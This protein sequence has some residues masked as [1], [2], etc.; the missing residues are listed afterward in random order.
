MNKIYTI[1]AQQLNSL[2]DQQEHNQGNNN[3]SGRKYND[4]NDIHNRRTYDIMNQSSSNQVSHLFYYEIF[5]FIRSYFLQNVYYAVMI[6]L[7]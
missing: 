1:Q 7:Y 6:S 4:Q 5:F 3:N 2:L